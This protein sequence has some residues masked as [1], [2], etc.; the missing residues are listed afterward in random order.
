MNQKQD[1]AN[2]ANAMFDDLDNDNDD[3][4]ESE[5]QSE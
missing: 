4:D 5:Q 3:F 2:K 1:L